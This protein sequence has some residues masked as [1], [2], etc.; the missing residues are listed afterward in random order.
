VEIV[1]VIDDVRQSITDPPRPE[2]YVPVA[3]ETLFSF[4]VLARGERGAVAGGTLESA[5]RRSDPDIPIT[6]VGPLLAR[7]G[8]GER[9][10][11]GRHFPRWR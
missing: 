5:I 4:T 9:L 11:C 6:R 3:Q 2:I 1:G 7:V 8:G 10:S